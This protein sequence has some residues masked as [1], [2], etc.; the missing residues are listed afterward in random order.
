VPNRHLTDI[1]VQRLK[2]PG[3]YFDDT[4]PAFGIGVGKHRKTWLVICGRAR[5][6]MRIGHYPAVSLS[7]ARKRALALLGTPLSENK[8]PSVSF[9]EARNKYV[10]THL[11]KLSP[12]TGKEAERILLRHFHWKKQL[13]Q[14]TSDDVATA[15]ESVKARSEAW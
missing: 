2:S 1:V 7:D 11:S 13:D 12:R 6:R 8:P 15:I 10:E 3:T 9:I 14:I 4:T 5:R